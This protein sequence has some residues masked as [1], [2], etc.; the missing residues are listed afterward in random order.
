MDNKISIKIAKELWNLGLKKFS[1]EYWVKPTHDMAMPSE[2]DWDLVPF[3]QGLG[4]T[5]GDLDGRGS[6]EW[7]VKDEVLHPSELWEIY[8]AYN[9]SEIRAIV[10]YNVDVNMNVKEI[11]FEET[12]HA[13]DKWG[14]LMIYLL[15]NKMVTLDEIEKYYA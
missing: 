10:P 3:N 13:T 12:D 9:F 1:L 2:C 15:K 6:E 8:P 14:K 4:E 7:T 5:G 11:G